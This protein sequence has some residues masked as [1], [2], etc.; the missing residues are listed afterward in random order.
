MP[1][2]S[3]SRGKPRPTHRSR[4][5][6]SS[7]DRAYAQARARYR[8]SLLWY[9]MR[10]ICNSIWYSSSTPRP[11]KPFPHDLPLSRNRPRSA[12]YP[13]PLQTPSSRSDAPPVTPCTVCRSNPARHAVKMQ[14]HRAD[15]PRKARSRLRFR[16]CAD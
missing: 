12:P 6:I 16:D 8:F 10:S 15:E 4:K 11:L 9:G 14:S 1:N 5:G 2:G 13:H 3:R 7:I